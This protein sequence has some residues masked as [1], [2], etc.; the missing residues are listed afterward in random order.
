M[1]DMLYE[2]NEWEEESKF[3]TPDQHNELHSE[4]I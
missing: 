3:H 2:N 1:L 4:N